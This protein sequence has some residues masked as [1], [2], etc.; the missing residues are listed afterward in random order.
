MN[1]HS[2]GSVRRVLRRRTLK[3]RCSTRVAKTVTNKRA[4]TVRCR[5]SRFRNDV[6]AFMQWRAFHPRTLRH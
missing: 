2:T 4:V 3:T 6:R 1:T 5:H